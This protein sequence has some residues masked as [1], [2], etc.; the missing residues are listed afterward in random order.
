MFLL[1]GLWAR[2]LFDYGASHSLIAASCV[3][4]LGI[5]VDTLE[6]SMHV[7]SPLGTRVS[8]DMICRGY[9]L[10]ISGIL[11][12]V[13]L[14]VMDMS[15]FNVILRMD[16]MMTHR[17]V[18][19]CERRRV[20]AYTQDGTRVTFKGDRQD[21]PQTVYDSI[22]HGQLMGWLAS[23]TLE[24][25]VRQDLDLP[26]IVCKYE[27]VF[28]NELSGLPPPRDVDF[29][30]ELHLGMSPISMAPHRMVPVEL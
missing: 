12:T 10:E 26:R 11:L 2:I 7:S 22:W 24:D 3:R 25:E 9:E 14:R 15:E 21:V 8:V 17:I 1:S 6:E 20:I 29:R 30:I 28:P 4:E 27:D 19:N 18:I 16:W 23:L 5:E 13:D